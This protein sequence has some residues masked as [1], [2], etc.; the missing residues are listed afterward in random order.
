MKA[1]LTTVMLLSAI[2]LGG[3]LPAQE[4]EQAPI[5]YGKAAP[6]N[7]FSQLVERIQS[8]ETSLEYDT[9]SGWWH[10]S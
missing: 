1:H 4:F 5:L 3:S 6:Q 8:G 9:R 10:R 7:R 2:G